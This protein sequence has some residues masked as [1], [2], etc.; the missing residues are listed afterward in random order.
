MEQNGQ[1]AVPVTG[2]GGKSVSIQMKILTLSDYLKN[3]YGQK[4]YKLSLESG[5][6]CPNRDGRIGF[7]GCTFC[8][9]GGSGE[10]AKAVADFQDIDQQIDAAK[11]LVDRKIPDSLPASARKYIAYFQSYSNTYGSTEYLTDLYSRV[12]GRN[13]IVILSVGTRPDCID[14]EKLGMLKALNRIKPVW[15]ELG[16][17]TIHDETAEKI[18]RGYQTSVFADCYQRLKEAGLTVI[19]H[20]ILG[21]PS[22]SRE[23][24]LETVRYLS[25]LR[26]PIDGIKL[27]ML[28]ILRGSALAEDFVRHPF[29][30]MSIEE[31][32]DLVVEC[33]KLLPEGTVIHRM[34]G[35]GPRNLLISPSWVT[36]K[37][38]VMNLLRRK[39]ASA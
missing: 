31:Y 33:L 21:L 20:V 7:G 6:T 24:M 13:D 30:Q 29:P 17:Q 16:L 5:C 23:D 8:S 36:D 2:R 35:D 38:R 4:N 9:A 3:K 1:I 27:Q 12:L 19:V 18:H 32:C 15:V 10:F 28:N 34:T 14:D 37:K 39:I 26:P 22:E 11:A 25:R